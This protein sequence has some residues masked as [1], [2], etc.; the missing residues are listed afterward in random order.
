MSKQRIYELLSEL[1]KETE[2]YAL[3][4]DPKLIDKTIKKIREFPNIHITNWLHNIPK[5]LD[6]K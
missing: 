4:L 2:K 6:E 1:T 3:S 5:Q